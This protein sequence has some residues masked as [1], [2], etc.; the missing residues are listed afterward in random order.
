[1]CNAISSDA[2]V[3][4]LSDFKG[5]RTETSSTCKYCA[6]SPSLVF[7]ELFFKGLQSSKCFGGY[8]LDA[9]YHRMLHQVLHL[10]LALC[11]QCSL[12]QLL[13]EVGLFQTQ[14]VNSFQLAQLGSS[15]TV[16]PPF[17]LVSPLFRDKNM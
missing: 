16:S 4:S 7:N 11:F 17:H 12:I 9:F 2:T 8:E 10:L 14:L 15:F 3:T 1:M 13:R 6:N 5:L